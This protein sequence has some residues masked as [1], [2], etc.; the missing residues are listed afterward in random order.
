MVEEQCKP[1]TFYRIVEPSTLDDH[2]LIL[3]DEFVE[4]YGGELSECIMLKV[5][6]GSI[7]RVG[8]EREGDLLWLHEG[9]QKLMEHYSIGLGYFLLF[10]YKGHSQFDVHVFDLTATEIHYPCSTQPE[11]PDL[12]TWELVSEKQIVYVGDDT[13]ETMDSPLASPTHCYIKDDALKECSGQE[14]PDR[15]QKVCPTVEE[16]SCVFNE[17]RH[18]QITE[19]FQHMSA[20][21]LIQKADSIVKKLF[22]GHEKKQKS[23]FNGTS[24]YSQRRQ[25]TEKERKMALNAAKKFKPGYP[26]F[27]VILKRHNVKRS[28]ILSVPAEFSREN[29]FMNIGDYIKLEDSSGGVWPVRC[30]KLHG[31]VMYLSKGWFAFVKD[32]N[33]DVGD[34][35]VFELIRL[36]DTTLKVS[37]FRTKQ[38][39]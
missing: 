29:N 16:K 27:M 34:V 1:E 19:K 13:V 33:L 3:P 38:D 22:H 35:C 11:R 25:A 14:A 7:W 8:L 28:F 36:D 6:V 5:P 37:I 15:S 12:I 18:M 24:N 30:I 39:A 26:S 31:D 21:D 9:F 20:G 32:K 10:K 4:R 23:C 2:K 17:G